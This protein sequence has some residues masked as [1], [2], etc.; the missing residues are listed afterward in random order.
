MGATSTAF[1][2]PLS[3]HSS[4]STEE[5]ASHE[6]VKALFCASTFILAEMVWNQCTKWLIS[7]TSAFT[8]PMALPLPISLI[9]LW[10]SRLLRA[11]FGTSFEADVEGGNGF[12]VILGLVSLVLWINGV[13]RYCLGP[14]ILSGMEGYPIHLSTWE[15]HISLSQS[16][17]IFGGGV[18]VVP[19]SW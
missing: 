1:D 7:P 17:L 8:E 14:N 10:S 4:V 15:Y 13:T 5:A 19:G 2:S 12:K 3:Y 16:S 11:S 6:A 18:L 9:L